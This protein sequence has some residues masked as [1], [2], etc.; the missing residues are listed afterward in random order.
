MFAGLTM[1]IGPFGA[2]LRIGISISAAPELK[3]PI[4]PTTLEFCA[5]AFAFADALPE[6]HLPA[7]A[8]ESSQLW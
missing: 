2:R 4:T 6:S 3:V 7:C 1:A 5:Y 8:V